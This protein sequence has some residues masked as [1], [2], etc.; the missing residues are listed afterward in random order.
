MFRQLSLESLE[1][2]AA[3]VVAGGRGVVKEGPEIVFVSLN[4]PF[5]YF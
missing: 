2:D 4:A 1:R 5:E 3:A